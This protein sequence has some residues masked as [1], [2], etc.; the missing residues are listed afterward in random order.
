MLDSI[1]VATSGGSCSAV[2]CKRWCVFS[3]AAI[4]AKTGSAI[5]FTSSFTRK[6]GG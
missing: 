3:W 2:T 1:N 4:P 6:S 5:S